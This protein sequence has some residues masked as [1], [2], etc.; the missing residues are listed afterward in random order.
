MNALQKGFTLIE[1]M[2]VVAIIGILAA[3]AIPAYQD[4]TIRAQVTEGL[5]LAGGIQVSVTDWYAQKGAFPA[6]GVTTATTGLAM[7]AVPKG[8]YASVDLL[9]SGGIQ[10]TFN[11]SQ[12]HSTISGKKLAMNAATN[13]NGDILWVCGSASLPTGGTASG[14]ATTDLAAKHLPNACKA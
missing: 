12:V 14:A 10:V 4:Y 2:I 8:K 9:A 6:A 1:L 5:S 3:I 7:T 13:T 11:G